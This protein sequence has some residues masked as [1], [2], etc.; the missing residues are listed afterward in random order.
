L[1]GWSLHDRAFLITG[2]ARGI[3]AATA[4][5][6]HAR[7]A[8]A[9]IHTPLAERQI[10]K[11]VPE[12]LATYEREARENGPAEVAWSERTRDVLREG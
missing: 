4:R 10:V 7:G 3:G 5:A 6:L 9:A 2:G 8:R 11:D 12:V 1:P